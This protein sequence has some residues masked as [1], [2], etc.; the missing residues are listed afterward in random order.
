MQDLNKHNV[1]DSFGVN[2]G[3]MDKIWCQCNGQI[4]CQCSVECCQY[5][6]EWCQ[7]VYRVPTVPLYQATQEV[8]ELCLAHSSDTHV[9]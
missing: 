7:R 8:R 5:G 2:V 4:W 9:D 1:M 6:V 3:L